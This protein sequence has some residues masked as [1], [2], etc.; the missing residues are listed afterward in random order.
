MTIVSLRQDAV[1]QLAAQA[2]AV[3]RLAQDAG[4]F[5]AVVAAFESN[6][7]NALGWVLQRLELLPHCELICQWIRI[8][9]CVLRCIEVCGPFD[10]KVA[11]P[12]LPQFARALVQLASNEALLRRVVDAVSCGDATAYQAAIAEAKLQPFCHLICRYVCSVFYRR[13]CEV[14]CAAG[15]AVPVSDVAL[16]IR[17]D[18]EVLAKVVANENLT[19]VIGKAAIS[20]DCEILRT[21]I[22]QAGFLPYCEII[23]RLICVW[24]CV[25][26][27]RALCPVPPPIFTGIYAVDEAR[28]FAL[29]AAGL[30]GQPRALS[31]LVAAVITSNPQAF[32]AIV[33]RFGLGP[34]CWQVCSWVC[35]EVCYG[36]CI[37]VCPLPQKPP[38]FTNVG[39]FDIFTDIDL[40]TGKTNKGKLFSGLYFK[41]GPNFAFQG[42][43]EL[44]GWCPIYSPA[45]PGAL[46]KYRFL[47]SVGGGPPVPITGPLVC[48][49]EVGT[50]TVSWPTQDPM[51]HLAK[52]P[53][54]TLH[55]TL[56]VSPAPPSAPVAPA[57]GTPYIDPT[58]FN[59]QPDA[60][61]WVAVD[62]NVDASGFSTLM[63]FDTTNV[64]G[65]A[66]GAPFPGANEKP[67]GSPAGSPAPVAAQGTDLS[68]T[69]EATRV[70][71]PPGVVDY[72]NTLAKIHINNWI[73][74]NNLWIKEFVG[75]G[76]CCTPITNTLSV[77]FTADHEEMA[78]GAW[79]LSIISCSKSAPGNI[80]PTVSAPGVTVT[81]R[82]GYGTIVE[83]TTAWTNCSYEVWLSTRAGLTTGLLDNQGYSNLVTFCICGH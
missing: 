44:R 80:T 54:Q 10:P 6:D 76:G 5:A 67:G 75:I 79:S 23:C 26:V 43:L 51:T 24:R 62:P 28:N 25:W 82:G 55:P 11:V 83:N 70:A 52:A 73:E 32:S 81:P 41:G 74:V 69:F 34:Y 66:G 42:Q 57:L 15:I 53:P 30:A 48:T 38:L 16:D 71:A 9:R 77:Q 47:Y 17:A 46:M 78:A 7:P 68:I 1:S 3:G 27:C 58:P 60:Q 21:A 59:L 56:Q 50:R 65:L 33:D 19:A 14:V 31:D 40:G 4:A 8:K 64:P 18:A 2:D 45:F 72:T 22:G 13:I 36:F 49:A 37:C 12:E 39:H 61:G 63:C 35:S 29:A 20:L